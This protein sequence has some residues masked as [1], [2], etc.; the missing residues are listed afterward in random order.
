MT[1]WH[2]KESLDDALFFFLNSTCPDEYYEGSTKCSLAI[3]IGNKEWS[4][5][6]REALTQPREYSERVV[7]QEEIYPNNANEADVKKPGSLP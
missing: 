6:V 2:A 7:N 5:V 1:T 3:V 4:T